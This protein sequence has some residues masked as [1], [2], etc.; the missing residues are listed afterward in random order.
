[1]SDILENNPKIL[2]LC[3][4]RKH[5]LVN[6]FNNQ[7]I[8]SISMKMLQN[9]TTLDTNVQ[10]EPDIVENFDKPTSITVATSSSKF[11]IS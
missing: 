3:H 9:V 8:F 4:G 5:D 10:C 1:L 7:F 2:L 11:D 6:N